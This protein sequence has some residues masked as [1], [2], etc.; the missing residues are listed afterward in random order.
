[1]SDDYG[2]DLDEVHKVI[3]ASDVLVVRF[4]IVQRRL[5]VDFRT[6]P[7]IGPYVAMVAP[8]SSV[9]ERFRAIKEVRPEFPL[10]ERVMSFQWPR[11]IAVM[12]DS[13]VWQRIVDRA[14]SLG[15]QEAAEAC[16]TVLDRLL[17]EERAEVQRAIRGSE[18]YQT[19]WQRQGA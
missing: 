10:P 18:H 14:T 13:G 6:K 12:V 15:G 17:A 5:L 8:A 16:T 1:M 9:E 7:G 3:E 4:H 2:V 11:M 19:L